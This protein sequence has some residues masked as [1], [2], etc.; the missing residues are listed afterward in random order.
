MRVI[1][2]NT[3]KGGRIPIVFTHPKNMRELFEFLNCK[4]AH[5]DLWQTTPDVDGNDITIWCSELLSTTV[6]LN[7]TIVDIVAT[8]FELTGG[9]N[10]TALSSVRILMH[11]NNNLTTLSV[12]NCTDS[13]DRDILDHVVIYT[14]N[15]NRAQGLINKSCV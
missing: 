3:I 5:R 9:M 1:G 7:G 14:L 12:Y 10:S 6:N 15:M 8:P 4:R 11:N 13:A 2:D